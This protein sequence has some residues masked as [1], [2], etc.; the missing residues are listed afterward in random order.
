MR[1]VVLRSDIIHNTRADI[2]CVPSLIR[3]AILDACGQYTTGRGR[4][5]Y[6]AELLDTAGS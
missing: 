2:P 1:Q 6:S 5:A 3:H 4:P